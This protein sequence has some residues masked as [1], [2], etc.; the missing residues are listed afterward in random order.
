[1]LILWQRVGIGREVVDAPALPKDDLA[2]VP[3][4][5]LPVGEDAFKRSPVGVAD[6]LVWRQP[7]AMIGT[8]R[9]HVREMQLLQFADKITALPVQAVCQHHAEAE[10]PLQQLAF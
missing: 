2:D 4:V 10:S 8:N 9:Y 6:A 3:R 7:D 1:M 5:L